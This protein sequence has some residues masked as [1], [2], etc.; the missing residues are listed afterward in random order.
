MPPTTINLR[1]AWTTP[2]MASF[3][4]IDHAPSV[5]SSLTSAGT[6]RRV[7]YACLPSLGPRVP[8]ESR[9][10]RRVPLRSSARELT[11]LPQWPTPVEWT[12]PPSAAIGCQGLHPQLDSIELGVSISAG[13]EIARSCQTLLHQV[14]AVRGSSA[15]PPSR[16]MPICRFAD[17]SIR[18]HDLCS[19]K[20]KQTLEDINRY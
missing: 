2:L 3:H 5:S 1:P 7:R 14:K 10:R 4:G 15:P 17:N 9:S 11:V 13:T 12:C 6:S 8:S 20:V 19:P 18:Q 16:A